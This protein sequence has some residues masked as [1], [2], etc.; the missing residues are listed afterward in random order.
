[1]MKTYLAIYVRLSNVLLASNSMMDL[2]R[3]V[4]PFTFLFPSLESL[5]FLVVVSLTSFWLPFSS[6]S[7]G[8]GYILSFLLPTQQSHHVTD[9]SAR[10]ASAKRQ[11]FPKKKLK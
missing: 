8:F 7:F 11:S 9:T 4:Y 6:S 2:R 10:M 3:N 1:M 5:G